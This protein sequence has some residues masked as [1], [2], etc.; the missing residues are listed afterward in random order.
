MHTTVVQTTISPNIK[1]II[2]VN[3]YMLLH[4]ATTPKISAKDKPP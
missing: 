4:V 1:A 3:P 2:P